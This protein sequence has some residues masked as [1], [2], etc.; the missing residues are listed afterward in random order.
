MD[1]VH[2]CGLN[3]TMFNEI[4]FRFNRF[5]QMRYVMVF[6]LLILNLV[7]C[8]NRESI[9]KSQVKFIISER[10]L[11]ADTTISSIAFFNNKFICLQD[12]GK[13]L[14]LDSTFKRQ[15]SLEKKLN[16]YS[17][18]YLFTLRDTVFVGAKNKV[19][20]I[21]HTFKLREFKIKER[22][23][24]EFLYED[25]IYYV[26][27]CCAG[28][29]GGSVFFLNK[30]TNRTYSYFAT[31]A[32]QVLKFRIEYV[33]SNNLAHLGKSMSF[34]FVPEPNKLYELTDEKLKNFCNWYIDVDSLKNY[35]ERRNKGNVRFC[36]GPYRSMSLVSFGINDSLYSIIC[37]DS[38]TYIAIHQ[39]DTILPRQTIF[40][41]TIQFHQTQIISAGHKTICLYNLTEG[42]PFEAYEVNGNGSGLLIVDSNRIDILE[43]FPK[44][45]H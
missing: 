2:K 25:T 3:L 35:S 20:F 19:F 38:S 41:R 7:S 13:I 37:N 14:L 36:E 17:I 22:V 23:F 28:E 18:I 40:N 10:P 15:D 11:E 30:K 12:N 5:T 16:S 6:L 4:Q 42:S 45:R 21:D 44:H 24:G 27:G 34:L 31:C 1:D 9:T 39:K 32:T 29:F 43:Q 8:Q 26:Y 33:V